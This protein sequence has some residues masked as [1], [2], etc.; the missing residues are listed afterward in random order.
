MLIKSQLVT[1]IS[2]SVGGLTGSH[3]RGGMYIRARAIPVNPNTA[4]QQEVRNALSELLGRWQSVLTTG[5]R[6]GW[7]DYATSTPVTGKLGDP[8]T[9]S[10]INMYMRSNV[11]RVQAGLDPVD[12]RP[13]FNNFGNAPTGVGITNISAG[14]GDADITFGADDWVDEDGSAL[15]VR[16]SRPVD[17]TVNYFKGPYRLAAVVEGDG[18]TAPTS[19]TTV[20]L[21]FAAPVGSTIRGT[22]RVTLADGRLSP[23]VTFQGS[24]GA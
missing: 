4:E 11:P 23:S 10:G 6:N 21:P 18:N 16:L 17:V 8:I 19:P 14:G 5:Q 24:V 15:L 20:T 1:Q 22:A 3:N 12:T 7:T 2:G 13:P 9:L